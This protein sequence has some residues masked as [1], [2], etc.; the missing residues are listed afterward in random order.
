MLIQSRPDPEAPFA[1]WEASGE[2]SVFSSKCR[3]NNGN[4]LI[5]ANLLKD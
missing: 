3:R 1:A 2:L 4:M 5:Q